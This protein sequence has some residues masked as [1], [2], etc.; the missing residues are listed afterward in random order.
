[1]YVQYKAYYPSE[2]V[3]TIRRC[4]RSAAALRN[5]ESKMDMDFFM[6]Q[7]APKKDTRTARTKTSDGKPINTL[8]DG[9]STTDFF[10]DM[11]QN[12]LKKINTPE[13]TTRTLVGDGNK[14]SRSAT[15]ASNL[16]HEQYTEKY[17]IKPL[18]ESLMQETLMHK[19]DDV[20]SFLIGLLE[21]KQNN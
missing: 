1:M 18:F 15:S 8:A 19:P 2:I 7:T 12:L 13:T 14:A 3:E 11:E 16:S 20:L 6:K 9:E 17:N 10:R 4:P 21:E 5:I